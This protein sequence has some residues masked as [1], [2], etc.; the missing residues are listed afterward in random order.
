MFIIAKL[1]GLLL[2]PFI[3]IVLGLIWSLLDQ[4]RRRRLLSFT[5]LITFTFSSPLLS[6]WFM[7]RL[8]TSEVKLTKRYEVGVLLTGL[9][10]PMITHTQAAQMSE[11]ADRLTETVGLY[12]SGK[13]NKIIITGGSGLI[14][15]ADA[16]ATELGKICLRLCVQPQDLIIEPKARNTYENATFSKSLLDS[17]GTQSCVLITSAFH[18]QRSLKCFRSVGLAPIPYPVDFRAASRFSGYQVLPS[19][20]AIQTW[21]VILH[22]WFGLAYY[23]L[24]G[25]I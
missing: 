17:L 9:T 5:I 20:S 25:Y 15:R 19:I 2:D 13:I 7:S 24:A 3:W 8:E 10:D 22:E 12:H 14:S 21:K 1:I 6:H 16:E 18:M 23:S 11:A 4:Q